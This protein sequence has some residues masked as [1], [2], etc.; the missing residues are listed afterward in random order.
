MFV[1]SQAMS[2]KL[3]NVRYLEL[4][5]VKMDKIMH[6]QSINQIPIKKR[7][8]EDKKS[9]NRRLYSYV[10]DTYMISHYLLISRDINNLLTT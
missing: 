10:V 8:P 9:W 7:S 4:H 5:I 2:T 6:S 1:P 3:V